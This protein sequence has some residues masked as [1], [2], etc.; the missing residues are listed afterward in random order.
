M[1][2][3]I[4]G[5]LLRYTGETEATVWVETSAACEVE[6]LGCR[7]STFRVGDHHYALVSVAGL[8]PGGEYEYEIALDGEK[9]WPEAG[10]PFPPGVIR[11]IEKGAPLTLVFGSCRISAPHEP[12]YTLSSEE[13]ERGLGVDALYALA[14]RLQ[15]EPVEN[16]PH[17]LVLL[18]DQ[19]YA[20]KPPFD[21]LDFIRSRR[22]TDKPPGEVVATFE[23]YARLYR[24]SWSDPAVRWLLS[25]VPSAMIFDDHEV[26]DDWNIS[27]VW[28][29]EMREKPWWNEQ[30]I[31]GYASYWIYQHLGNLSPE[32]LET[33]DLFQKIKAA[34][35]AGPLL[36][37]F[38]YET[39][40]EPAGKR[41][42]FYRDFGNT[43]LVMVDSRGGRVLEKG[44]RSMVNANQWG[45]VEEHATGGF[46]HLLLG[47]SVPVLLGPGMHHL[48][49]WNEAVCSGVWGEQ[50]TGWAENVRRSQDLDHWSSFRESFDALT[51]LI[52]TVGAGERGDS[53]SSVVVL[54]GDVH[55]GYLAEA[56]FGNGRVESPIYQAVCSPLRNSLPGKK[57][58][59]QSAGWRKPGELAGRLLA[60]LTGIG[61]E[62][63][64]WRLTHDKLWFENQIATLKL[65]GRQATLTFEKAILDSSGEPNLGKIYEHRLV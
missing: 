31:G 32:E 8:E 53:P 2:D 10:S 13:D 4:L 9:K 12:P 50:V 54:S 33:E 30:I 18:G 39:H 59:L 5:P 44:H 64:S 29:E 65:E 48:Q 23:E 45:W 34:D 63:I 62:K 58:R 42:S 57:S 21:T 52:Q 41:W 27:E 61:E 43:R 49:A 1:P 19:I 47:T 56:T 14:M 35:D 22:D 15:G 20:H 7:S 17:A 46:D 25:T 6:V 51:A 26:G 55:H 16:L 37:E 40:R 24:D 28:V 38:A 36:H 60:R 3:L 11:T